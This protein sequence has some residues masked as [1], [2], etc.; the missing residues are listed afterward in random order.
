QLVQQIPAFGFEEELEKRL[1]EV[2]YDP[3]IVL[4]ASLDGPSGI[5]E[6]GAIASSDP[7][8]PIGWLADNK[9]K[10]ISPTDCVT[11]QGTAHFS[12][13]H[14]KLDREEAGEKLWKA[15]QPLLAATRIESQVHGWRYAAPQ[16]ILHESCL[17]IH[18]AP[19]LLL[20]GDAFGDMFNPLEGA[21]VSGLEAAKHLVKHS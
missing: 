2:K 17:L 20:A 10:G 12:R 1:K 11:I 4:M 5:P 9:I 16:S 21:A 18:S 15:A 7:L 19:P 13:Q 14:W 3:A 8:S 6:P